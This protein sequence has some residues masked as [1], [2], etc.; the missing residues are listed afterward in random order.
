CGGAANECE[1][2]QRCVVCRTRFE[3]LLEDIA[4]FELLVQSGIAPLCPSA[5]GWRMMLFA[6]SIVGDR[7]HLHS[8]VESIGRRSRPERLAIHPRNLTSRQSRA[9]LFCVIDTGPS[10]TRLEVRDRHPCFA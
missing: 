7:R 1:R 10:S 5:S 8:I 3:T 2:S 6:C 9:F 4:L